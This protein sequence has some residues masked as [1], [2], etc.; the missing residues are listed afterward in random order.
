MITVG[1]LFSKPHQNFVLIL[2][3][4]TIEDVE[5]EGVHSDAVEELDS[6]E[7]QANLVPFWNVPGYTSTKP[8]TLYLRLYGMKPSVD[9]DVLWGKK[10]LN[11]LHNIIDNTKYS[12]EITTLYMSGLYQVAM[13]S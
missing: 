8:I 3:F 2:F 6:T 5:I 9:N 12:I 13:I 10:F 7:E 1:N 4:P 11:F